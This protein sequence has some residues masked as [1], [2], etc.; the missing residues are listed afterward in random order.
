MEAFDKRGEKLEAKVATKETE[1]ILP[2]QDWI[3][4]SK[5][6]DHNLTKSKQKNDDLAQDIKQVDVLS[7]FVHNVWDI[8]PKRSHGPLLVVRSLSMQ[9]SM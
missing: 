2:T 1:F 7:K 6:L 3:V 9:S 8:H 5:A 4:G